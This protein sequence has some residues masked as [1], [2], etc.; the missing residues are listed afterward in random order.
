[1]RPF[2]QAANSGSIFFRAAR[3]STPAPGCFPD[4]VLLIMEGHNAFQYPGSTMQA[5][6]CISL[7]PDWW[8]AAFLGFYLKFPRVVID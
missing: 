2:I 8:L 1:L 4:F 5:V 7:T 3:A 6:C